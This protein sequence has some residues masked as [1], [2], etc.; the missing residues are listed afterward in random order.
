MPKLF[1]LSGAT[2]F[3]G[4]HVCRALVEGG[5][6]V[7]AFRRRSSD[8]ARLGAVA[9][10]VRWHW[11]P[12]EIEAPFRG[13][14]TPAAVIHCAARYGRR[15]ESP[16]ELLEANTLLPVRL[17]HQAAG[18]GVPLFLNTDTVLD[19]RLNLYA[20]SKRHAAE[21][22]RMAAGP[23]RV[24]NLKVQHFYGPGDDP[25]KFITGLVL[26]CLANVPE[27]RLTDGRQRRDFVYVSDVVSAMLALLEAEPGEAGARGG[28]ADYEIG[29]G[30]PVEVRQVVELLHK[31]T[32]SR[33]RL[34]FGAL[35]Y[36]PG[37]PMLTC[38]DTAA[39]RALGWRPLVPLPEGLTRTIAAEKN[40]RS[41]KSAPRPSPLT[42]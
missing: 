11:A 24:L 38:A 5:H 16:A 9:E 20:L 31:L 13:P 22:L 29:S 18:R 15:G 25:T 21:W 17:Y 12:E 32:G 28:F 8:L 41:P 3:L 42:Q 4:S 40:N 30:D 34:L 26:Q 1:V 35:P 36:R 39:L 14:K 23:T 27:I 19:P 37:E 33:S 7:E 6:T 2:G 10:R